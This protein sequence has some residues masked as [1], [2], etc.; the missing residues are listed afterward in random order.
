MTFG[1][2]GLL[3]G[4]LIALVMLI[5]KELF[6]LYRD[7]S[8]GNIIKPADAFKILLDVKTQLQSLNSGVDQILRIQWD[9]NSPVSTVKLREELKD[10]C[11]ETDEDIKQLER[12]MVELL[13][14]MQNM[15]N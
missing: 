7:K 2:D 8:N 4:V 11:S 12:R 1:T 13:S 3:I 6:Q 10:F 9:E 5:L 14:E 15:R